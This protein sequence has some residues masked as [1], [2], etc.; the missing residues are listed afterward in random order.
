MGYRIIHRMYING[1]TLITLDEMPLKPI[2][3][4]DVLN[5]GKSKFLSIAMFSGV[6]P[7]IPQKTSF[8]VSGKFTDDELVY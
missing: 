7:D 6:N 4:G 1:N 8:L 3:K 2:K 5:G